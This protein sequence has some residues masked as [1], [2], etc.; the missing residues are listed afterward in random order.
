MGRA[1]ER[2]PL[3][4]KLA[5]TALVAVIVPV[6]WRRYGPANFL[7]FSDIALFGI[8]AA[9]WLESPLLASMQALSVTALET[10]WLADFLSRLVLRV[11][12]VGLTDYMFDARLPL[13]LRSLSLFHVPMPVLLPF[14][15]GRLG[16]DPR[17]LLAQTAVA[18]VVVPF[19]RAFTD[20][21]ENIN[22][23]FGPAWN[24]RQT[25]VPRPVY[26]AILMLFF[27]VCVYLPSHYALRAL[28]GR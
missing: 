27:P 25:R 20:P 14:L 17:A 12:L 16:Y 28:F 9:L 22:W 18:L 4:L 3:V 1:M 8:L 11:R 24:P 26:F 6:Y 15:V 5:W 2:V 23:A 21:E 13:W 19:C 7:W 10:V